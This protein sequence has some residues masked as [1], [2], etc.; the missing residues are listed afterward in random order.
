[1]RAWTRAWAWRLP[2]R[3]RGVTAPT[4]PPWPARVCARH[5]IA[6]GKGARH[7]P[8]NR[9]VAP[10]FFWVIGS[11]RTEVAEGGERDQRDEPADN[12]LARPCRC[13]VVL[14]RI[15][16]AQPPLPIKWTSYRVRITGCEGADRH[17][18]GGIVHE[19]ERT[20]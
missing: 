10:L 18:L 12:P 11:C 5:Q 7:R 4:W 15:D 9:E 20:D 19:Y 16:V 17:V 13:Q 8:G 3:V 14:M 6:T 2:R 1:L